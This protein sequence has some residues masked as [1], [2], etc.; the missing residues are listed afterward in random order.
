MLN[1][2]LVSFIR[3]ILCIPLPTSQHSFTLEK[4]AVDKLSLNAPLDPPLVTATTATSS[5][6]VD[7]G[8]QHTS[9]TGV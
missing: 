8:W 1:F 9:P 7:M 2:Q 6:K 4:D 5:L 3:N